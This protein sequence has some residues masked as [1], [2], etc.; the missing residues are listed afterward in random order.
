MPGLKRLTIYGTRHDSMF[1]HIEKSDLVINHLRP[2]A[3]RPEEM[4]KHEF[5]TV[6]R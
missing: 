6:I 3:A 4:E 2:F 5:N 1:K